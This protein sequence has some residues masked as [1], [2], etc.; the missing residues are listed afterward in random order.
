MALK[1]K[2]WKEVVAAD[3]PAPGPITDK[4]VDAAKRDGKRFRGSMR[5]S[6]GRIWTDRAF[7]RFRQKALNTP[8]P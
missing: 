3:F 1:L 2:S 6:T 8:L 4:A 7:E 5:V